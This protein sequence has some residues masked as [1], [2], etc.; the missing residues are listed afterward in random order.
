MKPSRA[1]YVITGLASYGAA[2]GPYP[3]GGAVLLAFALLAL[4]AALSFD[5][6]EA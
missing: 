4:A 2:V 6:W 3:G 1:L 5:W